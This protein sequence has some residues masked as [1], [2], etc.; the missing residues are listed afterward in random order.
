MQTR[1]FGI[2]AYDTNVSPTMFK[3]AHLYPD[4][5]NID[6]DRGN[7]LTL[8][9]RAAWRGITVTVTP[10]GRGPSPDLPEHD[11]LFWGGGQDRDQELV[12][13]D[14]TEHKMTTIRAAIAQGSVVL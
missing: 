7:I 10:V 13:A 3:I 8:S 14:A 5:M 9:R 11:L 1:P 6:G 4:E 2:R 12:F